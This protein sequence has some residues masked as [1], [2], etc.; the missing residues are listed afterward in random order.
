VRS[1]QKLLPSSQLLDSPNEGGFFRDVVNR[2]DCGLFG[3]RGK[4]QCEREGGRREGADP[5]F[6]RVG[7][8]R[9]GDV[10]LDVVGR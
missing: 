4:S 8:V 6:G 1:H 10:D 3:E 9:D 7:V 2:T 5:E